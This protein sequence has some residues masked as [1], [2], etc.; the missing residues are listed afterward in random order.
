M[1]DGLYAAAVIFKAPGTMVALGTRVA[2]G[3]MI[4]PGTV[5][6]CYESIISKHSYF[7]QR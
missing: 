6:L 3:P 1:A 7:N 5:V 2:P 4:A